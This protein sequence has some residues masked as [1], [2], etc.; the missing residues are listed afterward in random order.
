MSWAGLH[1]QGTH[2]LIEVVEKMGSPKPPR[3]SEDLAAREAGIIQEILVL[4]GS[5]K[6]REGDLVE[7]GQVLI[8]GEPG[9]EGLKIRAHGLVRA[10]VTRETYGVCPVEEVEMIETGKKTI[11]RRLIVFG[12]EVRLTGG[13]NRAFEHIRQVAERKIV[14]QGRNPGQV[15]ELYTVIQKEQIKHIHSWG[16]EGACQE[17]LARARTAM[18]AHLPDEFQIIEESYDMVPPGEEGIV[19]VRLTMV[20]LEDIGA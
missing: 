17:A 5:A 4:K 14:Y 16:L 15:I 7:R 8:Q 18:E 1:F 6:V 19:R 20:T 2:V 9:E 11:R 13:E 12:K 3:A 10:A